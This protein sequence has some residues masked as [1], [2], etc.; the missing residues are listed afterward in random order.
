MV[1]NVLVIHCKYKFDVGINTCLMIM[2]DDHFLL[3]SS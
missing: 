3:L 1:K 2:G